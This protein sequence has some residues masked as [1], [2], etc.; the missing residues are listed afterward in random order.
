MVEATEQAQA[1][2][3][4]QP[5]APVLDAA[6]ARQLKIKTG[7]LTRTLKDHTS[8][9]NEMNTQQAKVE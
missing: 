9:T 5:A 1:A 2:E 4:T 3:Q 6:Q 8:Y 7:A